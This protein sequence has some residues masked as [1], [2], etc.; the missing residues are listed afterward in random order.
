[1]LIS[2]VQQSDSVLYIIYIYI[3]IYVYTF[4][5]LFWL[6]WV[7]TVACGLGLVVAS[8]LE[9]GVFL[10]AVNGL[11]FPVSGGWD[12]SYQSRDGTCVSCIG[13]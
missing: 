8:Q 3:Y 13:R 11:S 6:C 4:F 7:F 9:K 2:T 5:C 12:I 1:M 10:V